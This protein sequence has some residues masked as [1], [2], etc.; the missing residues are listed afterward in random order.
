MLLLGNASMAWESR[1][2]IAWY[3]MA[4]SY[5]AT[6]LK[7][8]LDAC[9]PVQGMRIWIDLELVCKRSRVLVQVQ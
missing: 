7:L 6:A 8:N 9:I 4:S 5:S 1:P 2:V 3:H